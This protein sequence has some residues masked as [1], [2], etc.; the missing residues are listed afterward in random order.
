MPKNR[1]ASR[2]N[3]RWNEGLTVYTERMMR[4]G[5]QTTKSILIDRNIYETKDAGK[6]TDYKK[7][8]LAIEI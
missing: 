3:D 4:E 1:V 8:Y 5:K 7:A 2:I 6:K